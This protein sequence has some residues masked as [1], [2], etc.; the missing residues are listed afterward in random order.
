M[1]ITIGIDPGKKGA[2]VVL[3]NGSEVLLAA[4]A[5]VAGSEYLVNTANSYLL[6]FARSSLIAASKEAAKAILNVR[7]AL[8]SV[9]TGADTEGALSEMR[10]AL[11]EY[12]A[13][14]DLGR[15]ASLAVLEH[16]FIRP[17]EGMTSAMSIGVGVGMWRTLLTVN[18]IPFQ[19]CAA[20]D[21]KASF[22]IKVPKGEDAKVYHVKEAC[23]LLPK[24]NLRPGDKAAPDDGLA[25][26][27]LLALYGYR[28]QTS[29]E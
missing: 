15:C 20:A 28:L 2:I 6:P 5:P 26:A 7:N 27:G 14:Y 10:R 23:R 9:Y 19:E 25:D 22:G 4:K 24:L 8:S 18:N 29:R 13:V 12:D 1:I 3:A 21:W 16:Q 11:D 17:T